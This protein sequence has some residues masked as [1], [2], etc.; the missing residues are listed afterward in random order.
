M[1]RSLAWFLIFLF[2]VASTIK[3]P[4]IHLINTRI[5]THSISW[6]YLLVAFAI[7]SCFYGLLCTEFIKITATKKRIRL[8]E[9][10][11]VAFSTHEKFF[12]EHNRGADLPK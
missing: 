12:V 7:P 9:P 6:L 4:A 1:L 11:L 8:R 3:K 5:E 10:A 2:F